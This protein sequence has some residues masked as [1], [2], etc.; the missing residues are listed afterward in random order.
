MIFSKYLPTLN[1][2]THARILLNSGLIIDYILFIKNIDF[3]G[4]LKFFD[5]T[6]SWWSP[7][8]RTRLKPIA[9]RLHLVYLKEKVKFILFFQIDRGKLARQGIEHIV[10]P[11]RTRRPLP[12]HGQWHL[13][14]LCSGWCRFAHKKSFNVTYSP[15]QTRKVFWTRIGALRFL[16]SLGMEF[17]QHIFIFI[18]WQV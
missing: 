16:S 4:N 11:K 14:H 7:R 10:P 1:L 6:G 9:D 17:Q 2:F 13:R 12:C 8:Q 5:P 18:F 3:F 15:T